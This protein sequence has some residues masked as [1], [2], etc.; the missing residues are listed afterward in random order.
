MMDFSKYKDADLL[1]IRIIVAA[2]FI[3][4]AYAKFGFWSATPEGM[5]AS[6]VNLMKFLS[7]V[8]MIGG[9]AVLVGFLTR[10]AALGL[11]IIMVGAIFV[12]QFTM[13][14]GFAT[15]TGAGWNFPLAVLGCCL[16][17]KV[18]GPGNWSMDAKMGRA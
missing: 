1:A 16:A 9:L 15:P 3:F 10:W 18:F 4:A 14:I 2:I 11:A 6:M 17:L 12:L 7:I 5:S 13:Q 8:E